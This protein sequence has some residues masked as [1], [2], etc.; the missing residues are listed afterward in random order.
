MRSDY[1]LY[2][3]ALI[4]FIITGLIFALALTDLNI[5]NLSVLTTVILGLLFI[6][7]GFSQ[8]PKPK[9]PSFEIAIP[10]PTPAPAPTPVQEVVQRPRPEMVETAPEVAP[11]VAQIKPVMDITSVKGIK[12][13]RAEQLKALGINTVE[14]L[15]NASAN[16][17]AAKL[18]ISSYF[19]DK[20]IQ[21]A[22][23]LIGKS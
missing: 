3:V 10:R 11:V 18:K 14:D 23:E 15:A 17:L 8:R 4:C 12:E 22:K 1:L 7:L 20:W 21:N 16:E 9:T 13:K 6:A 5:R 19:T 2:A